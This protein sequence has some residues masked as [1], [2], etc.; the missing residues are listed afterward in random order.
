MCVRAAG[1]YSAART[2]VYANRLASPRSLALAEEA[3]TGRICLGPHGVTGAFG[4]QIAVASLYRDL[5]IERYPSIGAR[6]N[7]ALPVLSFP[8]PLQ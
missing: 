4:E 6:Q 5:T 7:G 3:T 2:A 1:R 8:L